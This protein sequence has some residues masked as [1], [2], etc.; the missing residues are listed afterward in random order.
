[1]VLIVFLEGRYLEGRGVGN[2]DERDLRHGL[3][4]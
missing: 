1:M 4:P 3:N 2:H